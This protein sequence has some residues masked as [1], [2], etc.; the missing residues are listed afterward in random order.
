MIDEIY[1][2]GIRDKPKK[3]R[4]SKNKELIEKMKN[5]FTLGNLY[6]HLTLKVSEQLKS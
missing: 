1:N 2:K 5:S 4:I 3:D 6:H